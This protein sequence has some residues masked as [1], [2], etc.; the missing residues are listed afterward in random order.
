MW[1][2]AKD[3][4][5]PQVFLIRIMRHR[6][7]YIKPTENEMKTKTTAT[8]MRQ[9]TGKPIL[10][11]KFSSVTDRLRER[12]RIYSFTTKHTFSPTYSFIQ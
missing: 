6:I 3:W 11:S 8:T 7:K 2:I 5:E 1:F 12:A 9:Q 10:H 4:P